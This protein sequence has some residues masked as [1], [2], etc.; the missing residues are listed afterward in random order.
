MKRSLLAIALGLTALSAHAAGPFDGIYQDPDIAD[1]YVSMHQGSDNVV[2]G[3]FFYSVAATGTSTPSSPLPKR[4]GI[5]WL[6][7]GMA[8]GSTLTLTGEDS[9]AWCTRTYAMTRLD[10]GNLKVV[11]GP[12]EALRNAL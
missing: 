4:Y 5:W 2:T 11:E 10:S 9:W 12:R 8:N 3:A 6:T 7:S 1:L